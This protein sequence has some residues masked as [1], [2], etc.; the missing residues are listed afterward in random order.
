MTWQ[1]A[2]LAGSKDTTLGRRAH[3]VAAGWRARP[4]THRV[5]AG[6]TMMP[7]SGVM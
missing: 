5:W 1:R 7:L 4:P 3:P 2:S 6:S